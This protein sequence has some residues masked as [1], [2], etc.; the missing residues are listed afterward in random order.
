MPYGQDHYLKS[1][2][3]KEKGKNMLPDGYTLIDNLSLE[4]WKE[5]RT[6]RLLCIKNEPEAFGPIE[7]YNAES[8]FP[9]SRWKQRLE[10]GYSVFVEY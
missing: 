5:Y 8:N 4:R 10:N 9:E 1:E 6:L 2:S 3:K 7:K